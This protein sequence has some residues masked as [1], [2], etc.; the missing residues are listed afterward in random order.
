MHAIWELGMMLDYIH[1]L[2]KTTCMMQAW[3]Q[4]YDQYMSTIL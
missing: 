3:E 4:L 1:P 2:H